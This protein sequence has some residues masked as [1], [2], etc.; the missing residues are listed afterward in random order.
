[1][2]RQP[3]SGAAGV[4]PKFLNL[5]RIR[6]PIGAIASI[7][8]RIS[9]VVLVVALPMLASALGDSLR[10]PDGLDAVL[11]AALRSWFSPLLFIGVWALVHHVFA[12]VR[13]LLMD[14]GVG[15]RLPQARSS[16]FV[17]IAAG[18]VAALAWIAA[19]GLR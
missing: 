2:P 8:H 9:G 18:L 17:S 12:G 15:V 13:H 19:W 3:M 7:L 14:V 5:A 6:F 4:A 11:D 1:M 10:G 16:A